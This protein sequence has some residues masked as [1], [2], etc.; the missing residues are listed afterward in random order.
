MKY[1][2][3]AALA[4]LLSTSAAL[5]QT[6]LGTPGDVACA[7]DNGF[8]T[9]NALLQRIA[10]RLTTIFTG[11]VPISAASLPLPSGAA[12]DSS[13]STTNTDVGP[14]GATAC[15]TDTGSCSLNALLQRIAQR[16]TTVI[17]GPVP[18]S[19]TDG[20]DVT[21]GA[22][23]DAAWS[24]G[25]G[26]VIALLKN[27]AAGVA[28]SV[29]AGTNLIG[30]VGVDQTTPGT[31]NAV[32]LA[33]IGSTTVDGNS[34]NKSAGTQRMVIATD[35]PTMT[36]P[37]PANISQIGGTAVVADPCQANA[38][39]S[40]AI[41]QT[42][43]TKLF[44]QVSAKKNY[45]CSIMIF[46]ADAENISLVEGTGTVCAT[47]IAAII[48]G[49]TAANGPNLAANGGLTFGN[50]AATVAAGAN[51]NFDVCLLQSGS[52]RVAGVL[53]YVQQ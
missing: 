37:Q 2:R 19:V 38:K 9:I 30:K 27:I 25:S 40:V 11:P 23:A 22:K 14:P 35:Q 29:P 20:G 52:G 28:G 6:P 45:I 47:S 17:T 13:V 1:L 24:S 49:T 10:Q 48:G 42:A 18:I 36:N 50:G 4:L 21:I 12:A 34:G 41:S 32:S 33:Q 8:C 5:A 51:N 7:T 44:S 15:A 46:G 16:L 3:I 39:T 26:S 53:T 43:G 31:T